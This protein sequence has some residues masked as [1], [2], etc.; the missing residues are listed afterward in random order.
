MMPDQRD[1]NGTTV[2]TNC[3]ATANNNAGCGTSF[4]S[5]KSFGA[6]LNGNAGGWYVMRKARDH[7]I[8]VWFWSRDDSSV[9]F[10]IA[11]GGDSIGEGRWGKPDADFPT[12]EG[13]CGY[14]EHFDSHQIV[15]D[16]T[17][18]VSRALGW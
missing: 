1:Q 15:F 10:E 12:E 13:R 16:L 8:S 11:D 5:S 3:D 9:P 6:G 18:C 4:S 2:S 14:A 7:G 17:F